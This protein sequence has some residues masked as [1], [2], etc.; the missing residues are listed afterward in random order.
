MDMNM[1][2]RT[3]RSRFD[4]TL[5]IL[6]Q[7]RELCEGV[8]NTVMMHKW[9]LH[10]L[11]TLRHFCHSYA[12]RAELS[13]TDIGEPVAAFIPS[14]DWE[15]IAHVTRSGDRYLLIDREGEIASEAESLFDVLED[16]A[17]ID[18]SQAA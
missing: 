4:Q 10:E 1:D 12:L 13:H 6:V 5:E 16:C 14:F 11:V 15:A 18:I 2:V 8:S 9:R 17:L 7:T 3:S